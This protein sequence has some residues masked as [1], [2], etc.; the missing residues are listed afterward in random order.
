MPSGR[1]V[2]NTLG[3]GVVRVGWRITLEPRWIAGVREGRSI[4]SLH[5]GGAGLEDGRARKAP[6]AYPPPRPRRRGSSCSSRFTPATTSA[7]EILLPPGHKENAGIFC[8]SNPWII[9]AETMAGSPERAYDYYRRI[10]PSIK[11]GDVETYRCEPY[12]YAQVITG[13]DAARPGEAR[14]SWLT[15]TAAWSFVAVSQHILGIKPDYDGLRI[16]PRIPGHWK[17]YRATRYFRGAIYRIT[18]QKRGAGAAEV[19]QVKVN[20]EPIQGTLIFDRSPGDGWGG[21]GSNSNERP[22]EVDHGLRIFPGK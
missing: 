10:C 7:W 16:E 19:R 1:A 4:E 5:H 18:V 21:G 2:E 17:G 13:R 20:G 15:G 14:N 11:Q 3:R 22:E 8:H 12:C 9:I 6:R